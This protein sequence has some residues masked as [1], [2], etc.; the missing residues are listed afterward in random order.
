MNSQ[1]VPVE[2]PLAA[3]ELRRF[4][5]A[6]GGSAVALRGELVALLRRLVALAG[7]PVAKVLDLQPLPRRKADGDLLKEASPRCPLGTNRPFPFFVCCGERPFAAPFVADAP[8]GSRGRARPVMS[9]STGP[10]SDRVQM[11]PRVRLLLRW[12]AQ[13]EGEQPQRRLLLLIEV[14]DPVDGVLDMAERLP[15]P[16]L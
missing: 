2:Q 9:L 15:R 1:G 8:A 7:E 3:I 11:G 13:R 14:I 16:H 10:L 5:V 12:F 4:L 6:D